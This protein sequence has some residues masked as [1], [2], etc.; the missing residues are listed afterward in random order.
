[1]SFSSVVCPLI[2]YSCSG[3]LPSTQAEART[4]NIIVAYH[5]QKEKSNGRGVCGLQQNREGDERRNRCMKVSI[6]NKFKF[7]L[8]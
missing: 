8:N 6:N 4:S 3:R 7:F 2:S 1:M 5:M